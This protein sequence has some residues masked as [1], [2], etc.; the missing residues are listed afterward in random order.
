MWARVRRRRDTSHGSWALLDCL[1]C[2]IRPFDEVMCCVELYRLVRSVEV[3]S[4]RLTSDIELS[5]KCRTI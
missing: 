2:T 5:A 3:L 4:N 1:T